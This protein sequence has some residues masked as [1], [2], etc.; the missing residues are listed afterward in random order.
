MAD[1]T[2]VLLLFLPSVLYAVG[3]IIDAHNKK[4]EISFPIFIKTLVIGGISGGLI[5]Q[6][7]AD[8]LTQLA[9]ST[10]VMYIVDRLINS[11]ISKG[12]VASTAPS[13]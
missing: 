8:I 12:K 13:P 9:S 1:A 5:S 7:Q 3:G 11:L 2:T 10:V 6:A 4:E